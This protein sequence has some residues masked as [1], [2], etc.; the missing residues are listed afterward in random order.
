MPPGSD[1]KP[2][3]LRDG[4]IAEEGTLP[5]CC[6]GTASLR[7]II[8]PNSRPKPNT[9]AAFARFAEYQPRGGQLGFTSGPKIAHFD[10]IEWVTLDPFS[11]QAA[12]SRGEIDWWESTGRDLFSLVARDRNVTAISHY[13]PAMGILR[14]N[15]LYPPFDNPAA[16]RA[17]LWAIDQNEARFHDRRRCAFDRAVL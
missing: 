5:N 6:A 9:R 7:S 8:A 10:R 14:F 16:R 4:A 2:L 3:V 13:M 12:L 15:Q 1:A 11:A 17:L